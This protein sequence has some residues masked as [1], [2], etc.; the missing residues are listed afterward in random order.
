MK[1]LFRRAEELE[2]NKLDE[3]CV[4]VCVC[5]NAFIISAVLEKKACN[6]SAAECTI[7]Q[8]RLPALSKGG[9]PDSIFENTEGIA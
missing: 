3:D 5:M 7:A 4:E 1:T 8:P 9:R 6:D 2:T